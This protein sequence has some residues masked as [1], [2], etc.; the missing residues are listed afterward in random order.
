MR[1]ARKPSDIVS[2]NLRIREGLRHRL[3]RKAKQ[4][5]VSLNAEMTA[6]LERSL[7]REA[8]QQIKDVANQMDAALAL[9]TGGLTK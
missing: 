5:A 1:L 9:M 2:P 3:K 7:D 4:N 8:L 6:R